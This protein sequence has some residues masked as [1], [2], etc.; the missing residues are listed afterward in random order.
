M[1]RKPVG[2]SRDQLLEALAEYDLPARFKNRGELMKAL[3]VHFKCSTATVFNRLREAHLEYEYNTP[4]GKRGRAPGSGMPGPIGKKRIPRSK[5][6][7]IY[8]KS[9]EILRSRIPETYQ[10]LV[11][12]AAAGSVK[13]RISLNC[14]QCCSFQRE[15]IRYCSEKGCPMYPLRPY[16]TEQE[17]TALAALG[18]EESEEEVPKEEDLPS[19]DEELEEIMSG[20]LSEEETPKEEEVMSG[21]FEQKELF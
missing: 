11:D 15:E 4:E 19:D 3:A 16:K 17:K 18:I 1:S 6:M 7:E 8:E 13:A 9:T 5:K 21:A 20:A 2:I 12:R 10:G 14:L